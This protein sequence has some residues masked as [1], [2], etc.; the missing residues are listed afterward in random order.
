M[1]LFYLEVCIMFVDK[2]IHSLGRS[3]SRKQNHRSLAV[4]HRGCAVFWY[5]SSVSPETALPPRL[6]G[7][8]LAQSCVT[9]TATVS[10]CLNLVVKLAEVDNF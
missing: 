2:V 4:T 10:K 7:Y 6:Q 1:T 9:H 3:Q 8:N 5:L